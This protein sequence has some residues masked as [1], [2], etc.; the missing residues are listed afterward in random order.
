MLDIAYDSDYINKATPAG[1]RRVRAMR[2]P[3]PT[4]NAALRFRHRRL[5]R[6]DDTVLR[7]FK[8]EAQEVGV[9]QAV[10]CRHEV[11]L[12]VPAPAGFGVDLEQLRRPGGVGAEI[13]A[14]EIGR[15][16]GR[17]RGCQSV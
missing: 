11:E 13:A 2:S 14:G 16:S 8:D 3:S 12:A 6:G 17:E 5:P 7:R 9:A 10:E 4:R 1:A 15:A